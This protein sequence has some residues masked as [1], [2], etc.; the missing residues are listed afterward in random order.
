MVKLN[1]LNKTK[2]N[3]IRRKGNKAVDDEHPA[4]FNDQWVNVSMNERRSKKI[5]RSVINTLVIV[6]GAT[7]IAVIVFFVLNAFRQQP[8][9]DEYFVSDETKSVIPIT[10]GS[11]QSDHKTSVVYTYDGDKVTSMKTYFEYSDAA[12]AEAAFEG[13]KSLTEFANLDVMLEGKY[14]I[15]AADESQYQNL[16]ASDVRQQEEAIRELEKSS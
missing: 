6:I 11:E 12:A 10:A 5:P 1:R 8:I 15:V 16:T 3:G 4:L 13:I 2:L 9:N 14:I 7:M